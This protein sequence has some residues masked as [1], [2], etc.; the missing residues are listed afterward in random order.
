MDNWYG[1]GLDTDQ[2][3]RDSDKAKAIL[4]SI[5]NSA[6][7]QGQ[8]LDSQFANIGKSIA[9]YLSVAAVAGFVKEVANVRG[10][11]Q[12]L[13][14]GFTTMLG[15]KAKSTELMNQMVNTAAKTPFTLQEVAG[16]AKQLLA[17]QVAQEDVNDT[18]IRLGN[19]SSGLSVPISRLIMVYGQVKAKGKLMGDDLRQFTEAGVPMIHELAKQMGVADGEVQKLISSG[20]VG[21][22]EVQKV[23][24]NLTASG[25]MFYNLMEEKSKNINGQISNLGDTISRSFNAIGQSNEGVISD[26][27]LGATFIVEH[28]EQVGKVIA[29]LIAVY[30]TYKAA[31]MT[32]N[33]I[34]LIQ[35]EI[36]YQQVL[37]NIANAGSTITLSTTE[38]IAAVVKS[39]LTAAQL[40]LNKA[41]LSNPYVLV[42]MAIAG[43]AVAMWALHDSTTAAEK[44]QLAY[45]E[46]KKLATEAEEKHRGEIE[47]LIGAATNQALADMERIGA[48]ESLKKK[49]PEIFAKYD[50]ENLKLADILK[51]KKQISEADSV[52]SVQGNK[53]KVSG[54]DKQI[55]DAQ[56]KITGLKNSD[57]VTEGTAHSIVSLEKFIVELQ[58]KKRLYQQD[59]EKDSVASWTSSISKMTDA[60]VKAEIAKRNKI[61]SAI[62]ESGKSDSVGKVGSL[63]YFNADEIKSQN[64]SLEAALNGRNVIVV[65]NAAFWEDQKKKATDSQKAMG[66]DMLGTKDWKAQ[67][68]LI[69]E[70]DKHLSARSTKSIT[71]NKKDADKRAQGI[72]DAALRE[73]N[74]IA[75][76]GLDKLQK[77]LDN[78]K[79]LDNLLEDGFAKKKA[80]IDDDHKQELLNIDKQAQ[81]MLEKQQ[82][83]EKLAWEKGGKKGVFKPTSNSISDLSAENKGILKASSTVVEITYKSNSDKLVKELKDKYAS[84]DEKRREIDKQYWQDEVSIKSMFSGDALNVRLDELNRQHK[85]AIEAN[86]KEEADSVLKNTELFIQLFGDMSDK[87]VSD[88]RKIAN[89][90]EALF[91]YL[92]TT[93]VNNITP[94]FGL[95]AD[96]LISLKLGKSEMKSIEDQIKS[97]NSN[98]DSLETGF[99][100]IG[101]GI[102]KLF[103][104]S[105]QKTAGKAK[106]KS[107]QN[108]IDSGIP[109]L[110]SEGKTEV[111]IGNKD[112]LDGLAKE[113]AGIDALQESFQKVSFFAGQAQGLLNAMS[114][115]EGDAAS[116]AAKSIGAVMDVANST[117]QG[118]QQGDVVGA[119]VAFTMSVATKIFE[120]EKAHQAA[121][122]KLQD[123]KIAQQKEY[124]DLLMK[125]NELLDKATNIFGTDAYSQAI[126][127][128][129]VADNLR[130]SSKNANVDLSSAKVQTG[131]H[132]TGLFGWGG[133]KADYSSL[134]KTYPALIDGQGK[135]NKELAQSILDNKTLDE[136]SKKALQ[137][138]LTYAQDYEDALK[139]LSD[140]LTSVFGSL[141]QD[142][143]TAITD[144]LGDT[145]S[146]LDKFA[147]NSAKTIEKLMTDIAYSMFLADK[148]TKLSDDVKAIITDKSLSPQDQAAK[149]TALLGD[150]YSNVGANVEAA[151]KFLQN[152]KDA[153]SKA[154][155][156]LWNETTREATTKGFASMN[157]G[158]ADELNGRFTVIQ[159]HTFKIT[160]GMDILKANS[161][162]ALKHLAG[163]ETNTARLEAVESGINAVKLGIDTINM[164]GVKLQ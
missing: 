139:S 104:G 6:E 159:G 44:A 18:L 19:I 75:K 97:I 163:I 108:K 144:N 128:A 58:S 130:N 135:L 145:Q 149:E 140:Y 50:I 151:N 39:K 52:K 118:F 113:K 99:S 152:S 161:T 62:K 42:A 25:G 43:V 61:L 36:A 73:T 76:S 162:Q 77:E 79:A 16:G 96:Q 40:A 125:Q 78:Q 91:D 23:I 124:N 3:L 129:R 115:E 107:G 81:D 84:F 41:M 27:I 127:Y 70:A 141:G 126:G 134:L 86:D 116:S 103:E 56:N 164:K 46:E 154:G 32:I 29:G 59:V 45:N 69:D 98:A 133:E 26:A 87:S 131:S 132:K 28:Y 65:K 64:S 21:F 4:N 155:F 33:A 85:D 67:Q 106:V 142:M 83:A 88:I 22:P 24:E 156:D 10:E 49:Y 102:S 117:M 30:G 74:L 14:T 51:L 100:K 1:I 95:S 94:K 158:S 143:M 80:L 31:V 12:D 66:D 82:E 150:F 17:Y 119:A 72:A 121:L 63:G 8:R 57:R 136:T 146:A 5:G 101:S 105:K 110:V 48:L 35:K 13:E 157:Q 122:K 111:S 137:S 114:T 11:F 90:S 20:K 123:E 89:E 9:G 68:K 7:I 34:N 160:E 60:Q 37:A 93:S 38:G 71:K 109:E 53:D 55:Q 148:F 153:A 120:A 147:D 2:L 54:I 47:K 92:K 112:Q 15:S 138:A